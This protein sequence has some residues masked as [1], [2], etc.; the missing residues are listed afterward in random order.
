VVVTYLGALC[1]NL[2][3]TVLNKTMKIMDQD[4]WSPGRDSNAGP[5]EYEVGEIIAQAPSSVKSLK[6]KIVPRLI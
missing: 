1:L 4:N 5:R 6:K 2:R 3:V